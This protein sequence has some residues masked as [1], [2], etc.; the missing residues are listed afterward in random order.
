VPGTAVDDALGSDD[1]V[2]R[3]VVTGQ[4][5]HAGRPELDLVHRGDRDGVRADE[6]RRRGQGELKVGEAPA[7]AE[8]CPVLADR[9]AA[10]HDQVDRGQLVQPHEPRGP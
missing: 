4:R 6:S 3:D 8:P 7:L 5:D 1:E 9:D 2:E 10:H